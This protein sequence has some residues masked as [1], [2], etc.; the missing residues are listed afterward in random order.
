MAPELQKSGELDIWLVLSRKNI[1]WQHLPPVRAQA[2]THA[3]A[4]L[5]A[6]SFQQAV[7]RAIS[8]SPS[9]ISAPWSRNVGALKLSA[10]TTGVLTK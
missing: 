2:L 10:I 1:C 7:G 8:I 6:A 5:L 4:L 3:V 9:S